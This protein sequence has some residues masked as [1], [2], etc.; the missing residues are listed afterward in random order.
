MASK[1]WLFLG[2]V[3]VL[4]AVAESGKAPVFNNGEEAEPNIFGKIMGIFRKKQEP[5]PSM[6][7]TLP[8]L[9]GSENIPKMT[10]Q[11]APEA[12]QEEFSF[13]PLMPKL[14]LSS[15]EP[16]DL[17]YPGLKPVTL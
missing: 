8:S 3:L 16:R 14:E 15:D 17:D 2:A 10:S 5:V 9:P 11:A 6:A 7:P 4:A 12:K 1:I 13:K